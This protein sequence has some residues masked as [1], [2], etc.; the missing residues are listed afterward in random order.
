MII[1]KVHRVTF[2][3]SKCKLAAIICNLHVLSEVVI[4]ILSNDALYQTFRPEVIKLTTHCV[5]KNVSEIW[6][7]KYYE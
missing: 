1:T 5:H 3:I 6:K 2:E 4:K 7:V